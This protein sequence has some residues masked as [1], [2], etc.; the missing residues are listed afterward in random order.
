MRYELDHIDRANSTVGDRAANTTGKG[1]LNVV[2]G[3]EDGFLV[4]VRHG[5]WVLLVLTYR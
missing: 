2:H 4:S 5:Y 3:V 1:S